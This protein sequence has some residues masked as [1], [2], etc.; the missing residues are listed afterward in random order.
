[1]RLTASARGDR[2]VLAAPLLAAALTACEEP[3]PGAAEQGAP[4]PEAASP[5]SAAKPSAAT[6]SPHARN[7][8]ITDL[9]ALAGE[10]RVAG[11]GGRDIDLPHA[12]TARI[13]DSGIL[14]DSGCVQLSWVWSFEGARLVTEQLFPRASCGRALLPEEDAIVAAMN[15]ASGLGRTPANGIEIGGAN[16]AVLLFS[17]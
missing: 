7:V 17:Q 5:T 1:M 3:A 6:P 13:D 8:P 15:G 11:A 16:G 2:L 9:A 4:S 10:Y 14:F 12:I